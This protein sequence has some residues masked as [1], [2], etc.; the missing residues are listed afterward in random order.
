[1]VES[2][3]PKVA[4]D[5]DAA[6]V[7]RRGE[8]DE[9]GARIRGVAPSPIWIAHEE[10]AARPPGPEGL[11]DPSELPRAS[12]QSVFVGVLVARAMF[13]AATP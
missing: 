5:V 3:H 10:L 4:P 9:A 2:Q 8:A 7:V 6:R 13:S 11:E 1:M 12:A